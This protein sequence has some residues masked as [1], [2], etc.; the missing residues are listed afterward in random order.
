M[1]SIHIYWHLSWRLHHNRVNSGIRHAACDEP[2][3]K[4]LVVVVL[5]VPRKPPEKTTMVNQHCSSKETNLMDVPSD[6]ILGPR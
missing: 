3:E 2:S 1:Q 4:A 6:R 5:V